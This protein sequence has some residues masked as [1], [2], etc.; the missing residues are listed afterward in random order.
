M[1]QEVF[2]GMKKGATSIPRE[3]VLDGEYP[4]LSK[5]LAAYT[6]KDGSPINSSFNDNDI[7]KLKQ[8]LGFFGTL[9]TVGLVPQENTKFRVRKEKNNLEF[10]SQNEEH[11]TP[12][13]IVAVKF[14]QLIT[15]AL[16]EKYKDLKKRCGS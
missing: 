14:V 16:D 12:L 9:A 4:E 6:I 8:N 13:V 11:Y 3:V 10:W 2:L 5:V 15:N 1:L 7:T